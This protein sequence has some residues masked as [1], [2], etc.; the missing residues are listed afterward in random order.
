MDDFFK[1][2]GYKNQSD[3]VLKKE[4]NSKYQNYWVSSK[5]KGINLKST[6]FDYECLL[7]LLEAIDL[8]DF[9]VSD[10]DLVQA[11]DIEE[12][13]EKEV[14]YYIP[15]AKAFFEEKIGKKLL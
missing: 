6:Y 4:E 9:K 2:H 11:L 8:I 5:N 3:V 13:M 15:D 10:L 14:L 12:Y 1:S 7:I